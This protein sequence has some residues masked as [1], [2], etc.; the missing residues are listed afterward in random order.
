MSASPM[1]GGSK[2]QQTFL[3]WSK[4]SHQLFLLVLSIILVIW[5][6]YP[7]KMPINIRWQM[8]TTF[9]R[10]LL[11]LLL[12]IIYILT[13]WQMALLFTIVIA[14]SWAS[15]PLLKPYVEDFRDMKVTNIP[16]NKWFVE[17]VLHEN[18]L[19]ITEDRV[20]TDSVQDSNSR[21]GGRTSR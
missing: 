15:R 9:G 19:E 11:V 17:K 21:S 1:I 8:S 16:R 20:T 4:Q 3:D 12:Y 7:E 18:P 6:C 5:A 13:G 2:F 10:L 14:M